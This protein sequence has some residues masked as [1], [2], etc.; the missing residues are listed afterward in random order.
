VKR[1]AFLVA[2][3]LT[4]GVLSPISANAA[5][6]TGATCKKVG[7]KSSD[8]G[9]NFTCTR[10]G[11]RLIWRE[12][13]SKNKPKQQVIK[14]PKP[15][16]A[17][18]KP[19]GCGA[20]AWYYRFSNGV[21]QRS[22]FED[23]HFT[24]KD[25]RRESSFHPIRVKAYAAVRKQ[26]NAN[27]PVGATVQTNV[28]KTFPR[29]LLETL[30]EQLRQNISHWHEYLPSGSTVQA[31]YFT[32][33]DKEFG[34]NSKQTMSGPLEDFFMKEL[35]KNKEFNCSLGAGVSGAHLINKGPNEGQPGYWF[36]AST[37]PQQTFWGP[38]YQP[39]ELTHS[40]QALIVDDI[41]SIK[42]PMN[43]HEGG[44]EFFGMAMGYSNLAWYSDEVD[45]RIIEKDMYERVMEI[46]SKE[47]VV[48]ML[49]ITEDNPGPF[50]AGTE[51]TNSVRWAYS[52]GNLLWE[53]VTAEY[54]YETYWNILKSLNLTRD[55]E[56]SIKDV[57][58]VSK[59]QLYE[60]ASPYILLQIKNALG[61]G[62][63]K[64][65]KTNP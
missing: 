45:K 14:L 57:L 62:W 47:D 46:K 34:D 27:N 55:Y 43:F 40:V 19:Y 10:F 58:G 61:N 22:F 17:A 13:V 49:K 36:A 41:W 1:S 53:W 12:D 59:E 37:P 44:A 63:S 56:K 38:F 3:S 35:E 51:V 16:D 7:F 30:Q 65:Y 5:V 29:E 32:G 18:L 20:G 8:S 26:F 33:S 21:M 11:A 25:P 31:T 15:G 23:K 39:H 60:N 48:K 50:A 6:K 28:S 64:S 42:M 54:G 2:I 4:F 52:M 9:K 24:S